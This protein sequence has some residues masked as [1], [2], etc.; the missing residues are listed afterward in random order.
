MTM[1]GERSTGDVGRPDALATWCRDEKGAGTLLSE[2]VL[3]REAHL[4]FAPARSGG[5]AAGSWWQPGWAALATSLVFECGRTPSN[6]TGAAREATEVLEGNAPARLGDA[7]RHLTAIADRRQVERTKLLNLLGPG[8]GSPWTYRRE[9]W[10]PPA[11]SRTVEALLAPLGW[12]PGRAPTAAEILG[13]VLLGGPRAQGKDLAVLEPQRFLAALEHQGLGGAAARELDRDL[14]AL[15]AAVLTVHSYRLHATAER[16]AQRASA[17]RDGDDPHRAISR[18]A[19][20]T[21]IYKRLCVAQMYPERLLE[22]HQALCREMEAVRRDAALPDTRLDQVLLV[23]TMNSPPDLQRLL[24]SVRHELMAFAFGRRVHVIVSDDSGPAARAENAAIVADA[25]RAGLSVSHWDVDRKA[26]FLAAL[27]REVFP[28]G[29]CDAANL[30][31]IR[32]PGEKGVPYGRFRNFLRLV[33]LAEIRELGLDEPV[34]TWLDQDNQIGALVLTSTGTLAKRHVFNYFDQKSSIFADR[35]VLVGGGG[36]TNDALEG[37]EKFW[38]AWGILHQVFDLAAAHAPDDPPSYPLQADITRFRPWDQPDT[39]ERL[40]R[41]G[42]EVETIADQVLVLFS[43]L[44]GTFR[45]KYDNQVQIYHPWTYGYVLP[46]EEQ[47]VEETRP[48]AGM[49][50]G[51]TSFA[52][53]LLAS[54]IPF[55]TVG[56]RGEDIFHLWQLEAAH[57][58]GTV[59]LTHTPALHTRNV[60]SGRSD[61]MAEIIDS[62]NG[63]I[64]REPPYLWAALAAL[65]PASAPVEVGDAEA[66]AAETRAC[67][68]NLRGE[69]KAN[70][71]AVSGFASALEPFLDPAAGHWWVERAQ[72]DPRYADVLDRLRA[73]ASDFK[74]ADRFRD[75]AEERLLT[76]ADVEHLTRQFLSDYPH[77]Q[78]VVE[79]VRGAPVGGTALG[80]VPQSRPLRYGAAPPAAEERR[81]EPATLRAA[82]DDGGLVEPLDQPAWQEVV[83]STLGLFRRYEAG[84][85]EADVV[86]DWAERTRRLAEIHRHYADLVGDDTASVWTR[87][88]RDAL[89]VPHSAPYRAVTELL[90]DGFG[91]LDGDGQEARIEQLSA[92][93]GVPVDLLRE[94]ACGPLAA[95]GAAG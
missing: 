38:V 29:A 69:A 59:R 20:A 55:I 92:E 75:I 88:F 11:M 63:R 86:L 34:L 52:S 41:E 42:E 80:A 4:A 14:L 79:H 78:A 89:L 15:R 47:L 95:L 39:L 27:N 57:G 87:V 3:W 2:E 35:D 46:G 32:R 12:L 65:D 8:I 9:V 21:N 23:S 71:A 66:V 44:L 53:E 49:P 94:A 10:A 18:L 83:D 93:F 17:A 43:T 68:E 13:E 60:R 36:Y 73:M 37:V 30:A 1:T 61:L 45:G 28:D 81:P 84:R 6:E 31:G 67:I 22:R 56:G 50:G 90:A 82:D 77:W 26:G 7:A 76:F 51:N 5:D 91:A 40:R 48:F 74:E 16:A 19:R 25:V 85:A 62:Y 58:Q 54:P 70:I 24:L 33:A 72:S 64:F